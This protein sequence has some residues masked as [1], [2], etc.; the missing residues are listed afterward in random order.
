MQEEKHR[1]FKKTLAEVANDLKRGR[2]LSDA[3][4]EHPG[5]FD[6]LYVALVNAGEISGSLHTVLYQLSDYLE[7]VADTRRIPDI[8]RNI[9][10][11][12]PG[13]TSCLYRSSVYQYL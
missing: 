2:S 9:H 6:A 1:G 4:S 12:Y 11:G 5:V 13:S 3:L 10:A 8:C 7:S